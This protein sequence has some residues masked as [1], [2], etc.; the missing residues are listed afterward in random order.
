VFDFTSG[1]PGTSFE[2]RID[3]GAYAPCEGPL[4]TATLADG[5]H[6][7]DVF[8]VD[9]AGNRDRSPASRS[10]V[11]DTREPATAIDGPS[12]PVRQ[13][14]PAFTMSSDEAGSTFQ[15]R[16]DDGSWSACSSPFAAGPL[17]DGA[18]TVAIRAVDAA[19]NAD[20]SPPERA[21]VVDTQPPDTSITGGPPSMSSD[22]TPT[23]SFVASEPGARLEC[24]VD[25][26]EFAPCTSPLAAGPLADGD[27]TFE[28]RAVDAAGNADPA[29]AVTSFTIESRPPQTTIASG[30]PAVTS[31]PTPTFT[32]SAS[33]PGTHFECRIVDAPFAD[34]TSPYTVP[35]LPD[36]TYTLEVR[37]IDAA[38]NV[39][40]TPA[41][42][43]FTVRRPTSPAP[44]P[45]PTPK[46]PPG[47]G[48]RAA[49]ADGVDNDGDGAADSVDPGCL[50]GPGGGY[51]ATDPSETDDPGQLAA[52]QL[53]LRCGR[54][55][56]RL[57][58]VRRAGRR[59]I[60]SGAARPRYIGRTVDI[61]VLPGDRHV[62]SVKVGRGGGFHTTVKAPRKVTNKTFYRAR[63]GALAARKVK[64]KRRTVV[65]V[66][67]VRRGRVVI[68]GRLVRPLLAERQTVV[69]RREVAC[70][71][72]VVAG[73]T[74]TNARGAFRISLRRPARIR[75][76][77]Y[78]T[79]SR[80]R[81]A[82]IAGRTVR[83]NSLPLPIA[84]R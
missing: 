9:D 2:C 66:A 56:V 61:R 83:T 63:L 7:F 42:W 23:F 35:A 78:V 10:F 41:Q 25:D 65:A 46:P 49:C 68:R 24:H 55:A 54:A 32:F 12:G 47:G 34:C 77:I 37:A 26:A 27:H 71:R 69:I 20:P 39:D 43:P 19:G 70:N 17:P 14:R 1:E 73:R 74:R 8:A 30:P 76:A 11:V 6:S 44:T 57:I 22:S 72:L 3:E 50:S 16:V 4:R 64:L 75:A 28:V 40:A 80:V 52:P 84:L 31:D 82:A 67:R 79:S 38:G 45:T 33:E 15:C 53:A 5:P 58:D 29:P 21:I 51:V 36:G 62:A 81:H 13:S 48:S 59:V 60:V 18:H